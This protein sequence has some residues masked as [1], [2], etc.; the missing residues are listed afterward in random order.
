MLRTLQLRSRVAHRRLDARQVA[1]PEQ[2]AAL[3]AA[4]TGAT[5]STHRINRA[6]GQASYVRQIHGGTDAAG[7]HGVKRGILR[8]VT[9]AKHRREN[10]FDN[11]SQR[12]ALRLEAT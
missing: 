7:G 10:N 12:S 11:G 9:Y 5:A 2:L 6:D 3:Y 8:V 1:D 4:P